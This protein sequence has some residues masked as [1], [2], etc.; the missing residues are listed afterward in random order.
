MDAKEAMLVITLA[1]PTT[2]YRGRKVIVT[3]F[4]KHGSRLWSKAL[5]RRHAQVL[6]Q[7]WSPEE[8]ALPGIRLSLGQR[9]AGVHF[10]ETSLPPN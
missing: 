6:A 7:V 9:G 1:T 4:D 3:A 2:P 5:T 10:T 8:Q